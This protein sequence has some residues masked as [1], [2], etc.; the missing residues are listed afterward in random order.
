MWLFPVTFSFLPIGTGKIS[1]LY[2]L[3]YILFLMDDSHKKIYFKT[4]FCIFFLAVYA[5]F[6]TL[7]NGVYDYSLPYLFTL[8]I[9][10][11]S[12]GAIY[13]S[14]L[15]KINKL[16]DEII[17]KYLLISGLILSLCVLALI[18]SPEARDISLDLLPQYGNIDALRVSRVRG[19]SN[20]GGSDHSIQ[21]AICA[22]GCI[23]L[24][25]TSNQLMLKIFSLVVVICLLVS[26]IFVARTGFIV[27]IVI[28]VSSFL[29]FKRI[30]L[31]HLLYIFVSIYFMAVFSPWLIDLVD[32]LTDDVFTNNTLPWFLDTFSIFLSGELNSSNSE[33]AEM[34][35]LPTDIISNI[36]GA[37]SYSDFL[38]YNYSDSGFVKMV[39]SFGLPLTFIFSLLIVLLVFYTF[40]SG[41]DFDRLLSVFVLIVLV[42]TI[43]EPFILKI[44][45]AH[46]IYFL[47]YKNIIRYKVVE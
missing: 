6:I 45:S 15:Y 24:F 37:G 7:L 26:V 28:I 42:L 21:L 38:T 32:F 3:P 44:G 47:L 10:E 2:F 34:I 29:I 17:A 40:K 25:M 23:Y 13:F 27:S 36:F 14:Y 46:I 5:L 22:I 30:V 4:F 1:A 41:T 39:F 43:K 19:F 16:N 35:F 31:K 8:H 9:I 12:P 33:L 20:G 18:V 11:F